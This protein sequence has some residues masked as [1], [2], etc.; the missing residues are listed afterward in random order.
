MERYGIATI[1]PA[2][3]P[4]HTTAGKDNKIKIAIIAAKN[5]RV[6]GWNIALA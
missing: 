1:R 3:E 6:R 4:G 2:G 5:L